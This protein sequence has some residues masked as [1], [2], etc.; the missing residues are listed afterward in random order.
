MQTP[1][2]ATQTRYI[3]FFR[4]HVDP[5]LAIAEHFTQSENEA[6]LIATEVLAA[7]WS[8]FALL[9]PQSRHPALLD[10]LY[11]RIWEAPKPPP[12]LVE[13]P[14]AP[15]D[16]EW[17][18]LRP[19]DAWAGTLLLR[20]AEALDTRIDWPLLHLMVR[21]DLSAQTWALITQRPSPETSRR[22]ASYQLGA[23]R[24]VAAAALLTAGP[25]CP[26]RPALLPPFSPTAPSLPATQVPSNAVAHMTAHTATCVVC[27]GFV[28][29]LVPTPRLI[30][31]ASF[32]SPGPAGR[33]RILD[34]VFASERPRRR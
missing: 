15:I 12:R 7:A 2:T 30:A 9:D 33:Q 3:E 14:Y 29:F 28:E 19:S 13:L 24:A 6:V 17:S 18:A 4:A 21:A 5:A 10:H 20:N 1:A 31:V 32:T 11:R 16:G 22:I 34:Q 27:N 23:H 8:R 25:A 26:T